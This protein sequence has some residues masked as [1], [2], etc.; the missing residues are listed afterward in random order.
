M[1]FTEK[2]VPHPS[3]RIETT[4]SQL[5]ECTFAVAPIRQSPGSNRA[6]LQK[7]KANGTGNEAQFRNLRCMAK[8]HSILIPYNARPYSKPKNFI[9]LGEFRLTYY[10]RRRRRT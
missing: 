5:E 2:V 8:N 7:L 3:L 9:K 4:C 10:S 1:K 6:N